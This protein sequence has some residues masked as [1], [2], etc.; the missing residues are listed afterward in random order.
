MD[1]KG[2]LQNWEKRDMECKEKCMEWLKTVLFKPDLGIMVQ[3][4]Q[5]Q[6][7]AIGTFSQ[8]IH[9]VILKAYITGETS[10]DHVRLFFSTLGGSF[11]TKPQKNM[12]IWCEIALIECESGR[13][14]QT[15]DEFKLKMGRIHILVQCL[16]TEYSMPVNPQ[17]RV[18][19][20]GDSGRALDMV[21]EFGAWML[22][23][24]MASYYPDKLLTI[25]ELRRDNFLLH[26][27]PQL[28]QF[29]IDSGLLNNSGVI[30]HARLNQIAID[31]QGLDQADQLARRQAFERSV[32]T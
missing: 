30:D 23:Y 32:S 22:Y 11:M 1:D 12:C 31:I 29:W 17:S 4:F 6:G 10:L 19:F 7:F 14:P 15:M 5:Q 8:Q 28:V 18:S 24:S 21:R 13:H 9:Q 2:K 26:H 25:D 20:M 3:L 16:A 27:S